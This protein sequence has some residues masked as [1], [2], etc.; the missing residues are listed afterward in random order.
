MNVLIDKQNAEML[1]ILE[2]EQEAEN[3]REERFMHATL[4]EKK[5]LEREFGMERAK[6]QARIQK[7]SE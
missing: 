7:L 4:E 3:K 2:E 6:A 5:R 1:K